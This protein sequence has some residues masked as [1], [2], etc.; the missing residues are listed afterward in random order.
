MIET[1][2]QRNRCRCSD[3]ENWLDGI[4]LSA[5]FLKSK[6]RKRDPTLRFSS[7]YSELDVYAHTYAH[8]YFAYRD[9]ETWSKIYQN[10]PQEQ[11]DL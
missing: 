9:V 6:L 7:K 11:V 3:F 2:Q 1:S 4:I 8:C 5:A 10:E